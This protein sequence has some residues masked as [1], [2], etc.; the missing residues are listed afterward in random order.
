MV[1]R[2]LLALIKAVAQYLHTTPG[3]IQ[4]EAR[5]PLA[6]GDGERVIVRDLRYKDMKGMNELH[7]Y[8]YPRAGGKG[9]TIRT[10]QRKEPL[11]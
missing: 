8:A 9:Y 3:M 6:G 1:N 7:F 10:S 2:E 4:M 11:K 5:E